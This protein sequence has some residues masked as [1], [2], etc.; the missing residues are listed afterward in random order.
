ME[1][2][3]ELE[4]VLTRFFGAF[5]AGDVDT[6]LSMWD[7]DED[8][9]W[10]GSDPAERWSTWA[11]IEGVVRA[12]FAEMGGSIPF[13]VDR[14]EAWSEGTVAWA[15]AELTLEMGEPVGVRYSAVWHLVGGQWRMVHGHTSVPVGNIE[16]LGTELTT[17]I[18]LVAAAVEAERPDL[19]P[20]AAPD[21]TVTLLFT[22]IEGSTER[23]ARLGDEVWLAI[24]RQH[25]DIV[26]RELSA[27][28]GYEVK[29]LGDGFMIAFARPRDG[30]RC[31]L[32]IQRSLADAGLEIRIRAGLHVGEAVR[33]DDDYY[34]AVVN[35]A[36]RVAGAAQGGEVLVS[37]AVRALLADTP[38][39]DFGPA[40]STVLKGFPGEHDLQA[41]L[42]T[43]PDTAV[44]AAG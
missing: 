19:S 20:G 14:V 26:R 36:A 11:E 4:A 21:G 18:D 33:I 44:D 42:A 6:V 40:R 12:Q 1:R 39:L 13:R 37:P 3:A 38:E 35:M 34:G 8:V 9:L 22:D 32:S 25:H 15:C 5:R 27:H 30:A 23:N 43:V 29:S 28:G 41:V 7:G 2:S 24:L 16:S 17:G 10:L 31:A